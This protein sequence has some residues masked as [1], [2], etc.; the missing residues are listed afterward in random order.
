MPI[1]DYPVLF[2]KPRTALMG[3]YPEKIVVPKVAQDGSSDYEAEL[4]I[5][6]S[7]TGK[8]IPEKDAMDYILGYTCGNDVSA[9]TE[10]FR[11]S[12]WSFSKG[13][14]EGEERLWILLIGYKI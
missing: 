5:I 1:P 8:D 2:I 9:R 7:K 14:Y 13:M 3:S 4:T 10:Q 12:Q 6:I 11:N